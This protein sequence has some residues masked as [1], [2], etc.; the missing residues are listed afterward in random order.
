[1]LD[2]ASTEPSLAVGF[3]TL[4]VRRFKDPSNIEYLGRSFIVSSHVLVGATLFLF[5]TLLVAKAW[6]NLDVVPEKA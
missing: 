1:M 3:V 4:G 2:S 5:A 6:R